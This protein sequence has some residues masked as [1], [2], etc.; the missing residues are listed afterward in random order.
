MGADQIN[1]DQGYV[2]QGAKS[3]GQDFHCQG[4]YSRNHHRADPKDTPCASIW[5]EA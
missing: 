2:H 4:S 3:L 1:D 5:D